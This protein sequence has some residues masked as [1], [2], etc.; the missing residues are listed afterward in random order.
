MFTGVWQAIGCTGEKHIK[1][2]A[3]YTTTK[4][5]N[6][7][8]LKLLQSNQT[9]L[10]ISFRFCAS[11][12]IA[13]SIEWQLSHSLQQFTKL[14]HYSNRAG[15]ISLISCSAPIYRTLTCEM[16]CKNL[17]EGQNIVIQFAFLFSL[18]NQRKYQSCS[19]RLHFAIVACIYSNL[20]IVSVS[21]MCV[22]NAQRGNNEKSNN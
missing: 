15:V 20:R 2:S 12:T 6:N 3:F 13:K 21:A 10:L 18:A 9:N 19:L 22:C 14:T 7:S 1:C 16:R 11:K 5:E 8:T 17:N 4:K